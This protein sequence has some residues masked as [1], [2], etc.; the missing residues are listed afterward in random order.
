[1]IALELI[2]F[3]RVFNTIVEKFVE[4]RNVTAVTSP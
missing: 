4:K 3:G 1:M 2:S